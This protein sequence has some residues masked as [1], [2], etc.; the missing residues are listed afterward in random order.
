VFSFYG[1]KIITTGE[2]GMIVTNNKKFYDQAR[3]LRDQAMSKS[4]R[5]FHSQ[6]GFNYRLTNI[7]AAIGLAQLENIEYIIKRKIEIANTYNE[8][9]NNVEEVGLPPAEEWAKNVFWMYSTLIKNGMRDKLMKGLSEKGI[10]TRPFFIPM[11][12]LPPYRTK[13]KFPV[14]DRLSKQGINLPCFVDINDKKIKYVCSQIKDIL[15]KENKNEKSFM[16][17]SAS[18]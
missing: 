14:S 4:K 18:R 2:G 16:Y 9:L 10:D 11:H 12:R 6:I 15:V 5:Y 7:Q 17:K 8:L 1:N 3:F 13:E